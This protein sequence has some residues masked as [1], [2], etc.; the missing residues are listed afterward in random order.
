[1]YDVAQPGNKESCT[2]ELPIFL[3]TENIAEQD[4]SALYPVENYGP[5]QERAFLYVDPW[6][7]YPSAARVVTACR[8]H[9]P[10]AG[11]RNGQLHHR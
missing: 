3:D 11:R 2:V 4:Q 1:M 7:T 9:Q 6:G 8:R 5:F 10:S